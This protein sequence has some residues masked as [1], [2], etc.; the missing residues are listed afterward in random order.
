[1]KGTSEL[2]FAV[3]ALVSATI[4]WSNHYWLGGLAWL[5][6]GLIQL[7]YFCLKNSWRRLSLVLITLTIVGG[8]VGSLVLTNWHPVSL[9]LCVLLVPVLVITYRHQYHQ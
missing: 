3:V 1:M 4:S 7:S 8:S 9:V 5:G 2:I 6:V